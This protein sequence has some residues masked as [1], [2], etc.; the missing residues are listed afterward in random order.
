MYAT[1]CGLEM[2]LRYLVAYMRA[3]A[4]ILSKLVNELQFAVIP[5]VGE[6]LKVHSVLHLH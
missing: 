3:P 2:Y 4:E 6:R 1:V 5:P